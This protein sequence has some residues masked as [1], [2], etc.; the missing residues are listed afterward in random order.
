MKKAIKYLI[1]SLVMVVCFVLFVLF[2][3]WLLF[4]D[5]KYHIKTAFGD[6]FTIADGRTLGGSY[7]V[8]DD[9]SDF[10]TSVSYFE[11]K[12][13]FISVCDTKYFK[14]YQIKNSKVNK[15]ICKIK[16]QEDMY[17]TITDSN[18]SADIKNK[19]EWYASNLLCDSN[20]M[21]ILLPALYESFPD[22]IQEMAKKL[23]S[24]DY[25]GLEQYGLTQEMINDKES[26]D[27]KIRIMEDYLKNNKE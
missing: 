1:G 20:Y 9:N 15:Y 22:E 6:S 26:I 11:D 14:C 18:L 3:Y 7:S 17:F 21:E 19:K 16:D 25:D 2:V 24:G 27:E 12:K 5:H 13:D 10:L 4:Y 23:T 8:S